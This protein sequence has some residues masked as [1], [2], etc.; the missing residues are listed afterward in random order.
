MFLVATT[1]TNGKH[2]FGS[3]LESRSM[4]LVET[5]GEAWEIFKAEYGTFVAIPGFQKRMRVYELFHDKPP[6][7]LKMEEFAQPA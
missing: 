1:G 6:R 3:R 4:R 2:G 7:L 5:P